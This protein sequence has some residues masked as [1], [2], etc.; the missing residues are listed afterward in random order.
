M[1]SHIIPN[2]LSQLFMGIR[3]LLRPWRIKDRSGLE[4]IR[5]ANRLKKLL[6]REPNSGLTHEFFA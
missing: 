4:P 6:E 5:V 1:T 2:P 3:I